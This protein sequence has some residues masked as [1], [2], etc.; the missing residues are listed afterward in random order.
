MQTTKTF[1]RSWRLQLI[2]WAAFSLLQGLGLTVMPFVVFGYLLAALP[3]GLIVLGCWLLLAGFHNR[4][5]RQKHLPELF[6][7]AAVGAA[8]VLLIYWVHW[9][10]VV[11]WYLFVGYLIVSAYCT[12]RPAWQTG[13]ERQV[14]A[15]WIGALTVWG[16]AALLLF[17][18][19]S[20]L[21]DALQLL[22]IFTVG[23]GVFQIAMPPHQ[24]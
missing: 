24:A 14:F 4:S 19:R 20:G 5:R 22:G 15:R 16:F 7:G 17:M 18:P 1:S 23:W 11:L 3:W 12:V 2:F 10:D 6:V 8:G 21:S 13:V 9:R